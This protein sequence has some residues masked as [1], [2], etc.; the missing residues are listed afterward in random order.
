MIKRSV[1]VALA[2]VLAWIYMLAV[3]TVI[4]HA[5]A[6]PIPS[7]WNPLFP[8]LRSGILTWLVIVHT[9]AVLVASLPVAFVIERIYGRA[10]VWVALALT[11]VIYASTRAWIPFAEFGP[12]PMRLKVATLFDAIKLLGFLPALVWV[13]GAWPSN[14][15]IERPREP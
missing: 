3:P 2:L 5:A 1:L 8:S 4:G 10:G 15:R 7:W 6:V 12:S 13:F 14:N 11:V 9:F